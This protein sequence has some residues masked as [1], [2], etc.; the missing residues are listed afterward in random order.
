MSNK[1]FISSAAKELR[2]WISC[3]SEVLQLYSDKKKKSK[4]LELDSWYQNELGKNIQSREP[5]E[6]TKNELEKL[7]EWKLMRGKFRPRLTE[8]VKTNSKELISEVSIASFKNTKNPEAAIKELCKLKAVGPAT[9]SAILT[10]VYP[11][12]FA[13]MADE[14]VQSVLSGKIDYTMKYYLQYLKELKRKAKEVN[15]AESDAKLTIHD[16][17][18]ALW[19]HKVTTMHGFEDKISITDGDEV[20]E[21][22]GDEIHIDKKRKS[23]ENGDKPNKKR[24][25]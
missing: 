15:K 9:A 24:K 4:L 1:F 6:L 22:N 2:T 18:I 12:D 5:K 16:I 3:Y 19:T 21:S 11:A 25:K 23:E 17:E 14:S 10:A 8:M 7:M 13:F 20:K